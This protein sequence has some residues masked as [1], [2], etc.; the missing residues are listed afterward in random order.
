[1]LILMLVLLSLHFMRACVVSIRLN[2]II[3]GKHSRQPTAVTSKIYT[4]EDG[5]RELIMSN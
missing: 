1:M 5:K 3:K 2:K 4:V